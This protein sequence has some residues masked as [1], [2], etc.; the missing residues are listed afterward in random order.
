MLHESGVDFYVALM[1]NYPPEVPGTNNI[2]VKSESH[3]TLKNNPLLL[4]Q[5]DLKILLHHLKIC[6]S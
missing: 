4:I 6:W 1:G 3:N 5:S 2:T